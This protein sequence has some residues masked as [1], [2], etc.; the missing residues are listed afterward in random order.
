MPFGLR[1]AGQYF[2]RFMD[3]VFNGLDCAFVY[4]DDILV[5]SAHPEEHLCHLHAVLQRLRKFGLV[6]NLEKC[7]LGR[8]FA[9]FLTCV[10]R[11]LAEATAS[12]LP[13]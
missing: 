4:L 12:T 9:D 13:M 8:A 1:N 7:Q 5:G 3:Q 11:F 10:P 2:Q 6:L